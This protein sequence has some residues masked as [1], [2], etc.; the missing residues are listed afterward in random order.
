MEK[1]IRVKA[2]EIFSEISQSSSVSPYIPYFPEALWFKII[3]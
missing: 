1:L 2:L 3:V